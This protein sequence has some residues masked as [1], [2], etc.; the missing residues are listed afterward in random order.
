L[1]DPLS[2]PFFDSEHRALAGRLSAFARDG[3]EPRARS[4]DEST[5]PVAAGREFIALAAKHDILPLFVA[6]APDASP[7][8]RNLCLARERIAAASAFADSVIAVQGLG[9]YPISIANGEALSRRYLD[10]AVRG[11]AVGAFALTEPEAGSDPAAIQTTAKSDGDGYVLT[12]RKTLIS[13]AGL[14]TFYVVFAK[15]DPT[16]GPKG[17]SAFVVDADAPGL[18][19]VRQMNLTAPH[20]IGDLSFE[21][22]RVPTRQRLGAP[23]DGLKI[24]L[25]TLDFFRASVG[26]AACGLATRALDERAS[27][28]SS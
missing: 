19:V 25:K 28:T 27:Q 6:S 11:A 16:A 12:G 15:T 2:L 17:L 26:A 8:L 4:A 7:S 24:A 5:D 23:G 13:N 10:P 21:G 14:A 1:T 18:R 22:C 3:V 20:P 9:S